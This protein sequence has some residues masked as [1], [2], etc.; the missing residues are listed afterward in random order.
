MPKYASIRAYSTNLEQNSILARKG[1]FL[2]KKATILK[3][4]PQNLP[5][6]LHPYSIPVLTVLHQ[7]KALHNFCKM[8]SIPQSNTI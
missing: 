7:N 4:G 8:G 1:T 6:P 5:L 2:S 3:K